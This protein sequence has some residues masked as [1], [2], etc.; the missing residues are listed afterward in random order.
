MIRKKYVNVIS[1]DLFPNEKSLLT[2]ASTTYTNTYRRKVISLQ[3]LWKNIAHIFD[4]IRVHTGEMTY[5]CLQSNDL[6]KLCKYDKGWPFPKRK[7]VC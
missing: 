3:S 7:L 1:A 6:Q 2:V 4:H 5:K